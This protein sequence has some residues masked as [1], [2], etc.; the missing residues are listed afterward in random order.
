LVLDLSHCVLCPTS[1]W[2]RWIFGRHA[3]RK[4]SLL[5]SKR[6]NSK[7]AIVILGGLFGWE[8]VSTRCWWIVSTLWSQDQRLI[9]VSSDSGT[10]GTMQTETH[11]L[12]A[13]SQL[14]VLNY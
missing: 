11:L 4:N 12:S 13:A 6:L 8:L 5:Q 10:K 3:Y 14:Y 7:S 1:K 9:K 2:Q